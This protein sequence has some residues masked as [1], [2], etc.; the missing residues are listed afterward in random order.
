MNKQ[1]IKLDQSTKAMIKKYFLEGYSSSE[2]IQL[3]SIGNVKIYNCNIAS[4]TQSLQ[5]PERI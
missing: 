2:I 3:V 1:N 4:L 5:R